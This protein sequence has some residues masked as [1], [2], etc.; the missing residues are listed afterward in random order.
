MNGF[1]E[2]IIDM[3]NIVNTR[4][5]RGKRKAA[6]IGRTTIISQMIGDGEKQDHA[7]PIDPVVEMKG[8]DLSVNTKTYDVPIG[9]GLDQGQRPHRC[10]TLGIEGQDQGLEK[11]TRTGMASVTIIANQDIIESV[12]RLRSPHMATLPDPMNLH[13]RLVTLT[14]VL[15]VAEEDNNLL[16]DIGQVTVL[17]AT[18]SVDKT[19]MLMLKPIEKGKEKRSL[20]RCAPTPP[21]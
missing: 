17:M 12:V 7:R 11:G 18:A 3:I 8:V 4:N 6:D 14:K 2:N 10:R 1:T 9:Q 21:L 20:L 16:K 19:G 5:V 15:A 13:T